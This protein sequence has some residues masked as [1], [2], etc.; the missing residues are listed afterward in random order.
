[1]LCRTDKEMFEMDNKSYSNDYGNL[2]PNSPEYHQ[3]RAG[4]REMMTAIA[5]TPDRTP[6]RRKSYDRKV[7]QGWNIIKKK[8]AAQGRA[9]G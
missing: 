4:R 6:V 8:T 2:H 3:A 5:A 7:Q 9:V 1:M